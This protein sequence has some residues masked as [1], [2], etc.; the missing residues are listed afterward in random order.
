MLNVI[1]KGHDFKYEVSELVKLFTSQ[2]KF[3]DDKDFG[4]IFKNSI[5]TTIIQY[6]LKLYI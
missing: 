2:F 6:F 4:M 3:V 5:F 1:L